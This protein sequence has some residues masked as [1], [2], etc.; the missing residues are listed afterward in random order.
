MNRRDWPE[1]SG[2]YRFD[3]IYDRRN[4]GYRGPGTRR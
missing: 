3:K 2:F 1:C 4:V